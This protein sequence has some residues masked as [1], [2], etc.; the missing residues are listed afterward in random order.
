MNSTDKLK[1]ELSQFI[2]T[3]KYYQL[4]K[5]HMLTDGTKFLAD[6]AQ[7][8][9]LML[10]TCSYL[11]SSCDD[12]FA[13]AH[14]VVNDSSAVFTLDDGNG[15]VFARQNIEYTD[16]PLNEIKLYCQHDGAH[17]VIM[18]TSEY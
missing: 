1:S 2:G 4:S 7:C 13:V 12:T 16:F 18:L 6:E 3:E 10:I 8:Y 17:W 11:N 9:W 14:L 15:N 5:F